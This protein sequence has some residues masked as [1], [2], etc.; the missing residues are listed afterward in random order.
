MSLSNLPI[1]SLGKLLCAFIPSSCR[2]PVESYYGVHTMALRV[3]YAHNHNIMHTYRNALHSI[4]L[5]ASLLFQHTSNSPL[6]GNN[7]VG[8]IPKISR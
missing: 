5:A 1:L 3:W 2:N 4:G 6:D 8:N 7:G